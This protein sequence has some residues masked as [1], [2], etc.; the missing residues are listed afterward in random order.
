MSRYRPRRRASVRFWSRPSSRAAHQNIQRTIMIV[1]ADTTARMIPA[2]VIPDILAVG[3]VENL[4]GRVFRER[5]SRRP[6]PSLPRRP[7]SAQQ[8]KA[9][10]T[11]VRRGTASQVSPFGFSC[12]NQRR[13]RPGGRTKREGRC[14]HGEQRLPGMAEPCLPARLFGN[15]GDPVCRSLAGTAHLEGDRG[16][17]T[18]SLWPGSVG[19]SRPLTCSR[20]PSSLRIIPESL[21]SLNQSIVPRIGCCLSSLRPGGMALTC[22]ELVWRRR[23]AP[24]RR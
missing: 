7:S 14:Y 15:E 23:T 19:E 12:D 11:Y 5:P 1:T 22:A 8:P 24:S 3:T 13:L 6:V 9:A 10:R 4:V 21:T 18:T 2:A 17:R 20:S 16:F